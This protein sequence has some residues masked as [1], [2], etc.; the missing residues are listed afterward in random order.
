MVENL[1]YYSIMYSLAN[2]VRQAIRLLLKHKTFSATAIM[3][4]ALAIGANT[5]I[6][7]IARAVLLDPLPYPNGSQL[8]LVWEDATHLGFPANTPAPG[9]YADWKPKHGVS[10]NGGIATA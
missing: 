9:N 7:S 8:V 10:G 5:A 1:L 3:T 6:F 4:L 2:D